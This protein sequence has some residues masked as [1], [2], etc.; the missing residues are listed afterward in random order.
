[1]PQASHMVR[2]TARLSPTLARRESDD[3]GSRLSADLGLAAGDWIGWGHQACFWHCGVL[4]KGMAAEA[5]ARKHAAGV[6]HLLADQDEGDVASVVYPALVD[7]RWERHCHHFLNAAAGRVAAAQPAAR[8]RSSPEGLTEDVSASLGRIHH[9]LGDSM[10]APSAAAQVNRAAFEL[11]AP[12]LRPPE[13]IVAAS[14]LFRSTTARRL[15]EQ[16]CREPLP[17]ASAFNRALELDRGVA[18]PLMIAADPRRIELPVW[19]VN[20]AG[21]RLRVNADQCRRA[22]DENQ[23]L[24]PRAFLATGLVRMATNAFVH[25]TGGER[26]ERVGDQF[27]LKWLG[28]SIPPPSMVSADVPLSSEPLPNAPADPRTLQ[29][30]PW[31]AEGS[32]EVSLQLRQLRAA[33]EEAP[34][35]SDQRHDAYESMRARVAFERQ[36]NAPHIERAEAAWRQWQERCASTRILAAR[37]WPFPLHRSESLERLFAEVQAGVAADAA[38][39]GSGR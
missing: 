29:F 15:L 21:A 38:D 16:M 24:V 2:V 22:L 14:E 36:R 32:G 20:S 5:M 8:P 17:C 25:G 3:L 34:R 23:L 9:A 27:W 37:D 33:I 39:S 30:D 10:A 13:R 7:G 11:A 31:R 26:Y 4:A 1:M 18:R 35:G 6:V 19:L 28:V 12:W